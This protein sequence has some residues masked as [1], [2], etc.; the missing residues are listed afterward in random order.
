MPSCNGAR[1]EEK[2]IQGQ[3]PVSVFGYQMHFDL[4]KGFP[5]L[6]TKRVPFRLVASE[7]LWFMKGDTNIRYFYNIIIIFGM[8]GR[9]RAG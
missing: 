1:Y 3:V 6:T 8:N 2:M 9:L 5:L 4:S 7:L